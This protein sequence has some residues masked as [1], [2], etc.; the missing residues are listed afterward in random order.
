[1]NN[2]TEKVTVRFSE[3]ERETLE[4][5]AQTNNTSLSECVRSLLF[6]FINL[7]NTS[8]QEDPNLIDRTISALKRKIRD[9]SQEINRLESHLLFEKYK[10]LINNKG[11][12]I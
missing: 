12:S 2:K 3:A 11:V 8:P 7:N 9:I 5:I 6:T 1:M 4:S 10:K